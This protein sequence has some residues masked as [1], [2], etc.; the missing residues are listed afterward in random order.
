MRGGSARRLALALGVAAGTHLLAWF[1]VRDWRTDGITVV[2]SS[3][4]APGSTVEREQATELTMVELATLPAAGIPEIP[5]SALRGPA[6]EVGA[7]THP[8]PDQAAEIAGQ[9]A[10][11]RGGGGASGATQFTGR[12]DQTTDVPIHHE[13]WNGKRDYQ[14]AHEKTARTARSP[15]A[16]RQSREQDI[17]DRAKATRVASAGAAQ[18][19]TGGA[20]AGRGPATIAPVGA[21]SAGGTAPAGTQTPAA[22][23]GA[24]RP[25]PTPAQVEPGVHST[26]VPVRGPT[27]TDNTNTA[28]ASRDLKAGPFEITP[29]ATG[30]TARTGVAGTPAPGQSAAGRSTGTAQ[31]RWGVAKGPRNLGITAE[32]QDPYF[33]TMFARLGK[34]VVYPRNLAIEL[35]SGRP[36][37]ELTLRADGGLSRATIAVPSG[38]PEFDKELVRAIGVLGRLP[39]PPASLLEGR[40]EIRVRIEWVFDP[41][42]LR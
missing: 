8:A 15:E 24:M 25:N 1:A 5:L 14:S 11:S 33:R 35:R 3:E 21:P 38:K 36:I 29:P 30:G 12:R 18:V 7:R 42:I 13:L 22:Q 31:T 40:L 26:D 32:A 6:D 9:V 17:G 23:A 37:A 28:A 27:P 39:P 41:G 16:V 4:I 19:S 2:R 10:A 20:E 34:I